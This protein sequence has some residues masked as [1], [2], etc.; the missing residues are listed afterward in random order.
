MNSRSL[1][2]GCGRRLRD[3]VGEEELLRGRGGVLNRF[4]GRG[5]RRGRGS[6]LGGA[7]LRPSR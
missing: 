5:S 1:L 4:R 2:R 6:L 7:A 3:R